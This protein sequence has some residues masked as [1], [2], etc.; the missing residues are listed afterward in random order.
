MKNDPIR[1]SCPGVNAAAKAIPIV[2]V[3]NPLAKVTY[4]AVI[5]SVDKSQLETFMAHGLTAEEAVDVIV[6]GVP[7][8]KIDEVKEYER[9]S[10]YFGP[11]F[12]CFVR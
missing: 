10:C 3:T 11:C 4:E 5:G 8:R 2:N 9:N 1:L 12:C 7:R 6:K